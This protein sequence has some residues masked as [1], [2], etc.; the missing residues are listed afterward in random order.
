M[1]ADDVLERAEMA[2][3]INELW[4]AEEVKEQERKEPGATQ[5]RK[6]V[7]WQATAAAGVFLGVQDRSRA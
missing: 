5:R 4:C 3:G 2:G 7:S 1:L 6:G